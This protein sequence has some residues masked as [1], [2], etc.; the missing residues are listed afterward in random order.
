M[1]RLKYL[2]K[3][4]KKVDHKILKLIQIRM[5]L[6]EK[7]GKIKKKNGIPLQD[8]SIERD[9]IENAMRY[10]KDIGV[11]INFTRTIF[12]KIIEQSRIQ[13]ERLHYSV[14]SGKKEDILIIGGLGGMGQWFAHFLQNQGHR[15]AI[16]DLKNPGIYGFKYYRRLENAIK[17][18]SIIIIAT[19]LSIVPD[20]IEKIT[21][22]NC[23]SVVC[24]IASVKSHIIP[25]IKKAIRNNIKITSI[26][27]MFGP[28]CHTLNDKIVCMCDCGS[29]EANNKI[30]N[31]FKDTAARIIK[32]PFDEHDK[33]ISY[34]LGLSHLVNILFVKML[35]DGDY[36]FKN[37]NNIASTTFNAQMATARGVIK[38]NPELY[39]EIQ[40]LNPYNTALFNNLK[41]SLS[42][43]VD[44]IRT[45]NRNA[46]IDV[47]QKANR[48][49][50]DC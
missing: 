45:G 8:W 11:D 35:M 41:M 18:K 29:P 10:A 49:L 27:P 17:E 3:E 43:L 33:L 24:D 28:S 42:A 14:Y 48:W 16:N 50:D 12:A 21:R 9:V 13:Q 19:P 4:I 1:D 37:L 30:L 22:L 25:K 46:F 2:R 40:A 7:I 32:L 39:Y 26:H 23:A 31:L 34:V 5:M 38:E 36:S 20:I 47:F 44:M 15:V 6:G